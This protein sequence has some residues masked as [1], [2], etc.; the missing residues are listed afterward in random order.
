GEGKGEDVFY[1]LTLYNE[2]YP[3]PAM[4]EGAEQGILQ[5]LY[6]FK[7]G[8]NGERRHR[9]QILAS[10][11]MVM[12]ALRAQEILGQEHDVAASVWSATSYQQL[13]VDALECE[14]WNRR[15]PGEPKQEPFITRAVGSAEGPVVAVS[16]SI[17]SVPDQPA[18]CVQQPLLSV[19]P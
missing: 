18:S 19:R 8:S 2:N 14:R 9:A 15:H 13:R 1:Y 12:Q 17:K 6:R 3:Q 16:D 4:P 10:G 7:E 11:P 5:G